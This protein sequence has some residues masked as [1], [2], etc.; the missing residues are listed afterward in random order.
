LLFG[1]GFEETNAELSAS[2]AVRAASAF[3]ADCA[4]ARR[5]SDRLCGADGGIAGDLAVQRP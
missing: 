3:S 2:S 1:T 4:D 5:K